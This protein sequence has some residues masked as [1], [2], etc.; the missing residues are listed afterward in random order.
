MI[1]A[2]I[3]ALLDQT[4]RGKAT[5]ERAQEDRSRRGQEINSYRLFLDETDT[6]LRNVISKIHE[7][8]SLDDNKVR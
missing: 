6:W 5:L 8:R 2:R 3:T 7:Q 1:H 4:E